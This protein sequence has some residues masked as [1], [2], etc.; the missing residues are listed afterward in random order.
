MAGFPNVP[1]APGVPPLA[2][3]PFQA[4]E[5]IQKRLTRDILVFLG[6][7]SARWG[8][9]KNGVPVVVCDSVVSFGFKQSW[10]LSDYPVENG[11]FQTYDKVNSPFDARVR[12]AT[13]GSEGDRQVLLDSIDAIAGT[14]E[15][16]DVVTPERVYRDVNVVC[17]DYNR[18]ARNGV[19]L[20][21][22][23]VSLME[24]RQTATAA[25]TQTTQPSGTDAV[26]SGTV[27]AA[28]PTK[29]QSALSSF[30]H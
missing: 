11:G 20:L 28:A 21:M 15:L 17:Y 22:V 19:G 7:A 2:R 10:S 5:T 4:V 1:F 27:Q 3:N 6:V 26:N 9:F 13:G 8:I 18:T 12:F 29:S 30:F 23:D 16:Y 24:V 14:V 25:F